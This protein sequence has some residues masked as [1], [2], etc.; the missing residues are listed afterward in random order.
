MIVGGRG[1]RGRR[2]TIWQ[3][4]DLRRRLAAAEDALAR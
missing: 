3:L 4:A 1:A 2:E